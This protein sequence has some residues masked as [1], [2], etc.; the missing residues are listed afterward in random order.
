[1]ES[2]ENH[3]VVIDEVMKVFSTGNKLTNKDLKYNLLNGYVDKLK[4]KNRL[5]KTTIKRDEQIAALVQK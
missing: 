5:Q 1:M 4:D 2:H 3:M